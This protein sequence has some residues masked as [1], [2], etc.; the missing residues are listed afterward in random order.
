GAAVGARLE[1]L[2]AGGAPLGPAAVLAAGL[3]VAA[4][5]LVRRR[6]ARAA[7]RRGIAGVDAA[8]VAEVLEVLAARGVERREGETLREVVARA[9][10]ELGPGVDALVA[11]VP[12]C[13]AARF[14]GRPSDPAANEAA[15][16]ALAAL[17]SPPPPTARP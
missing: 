7:A 16:R 13:Y 9:R 5:A 10:A 2:S 1:G 8:L 4:L 3:G 12:A 14:G 15:R 17:R 6:G 11:W